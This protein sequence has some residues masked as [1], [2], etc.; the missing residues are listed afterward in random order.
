MAA[1]TESGAEPSA[2]D[3]PAAA[4]ERVYT[5][6]RPASV[7]ETSKAKRMSLFARVSQISMNGTARPN[8]A[9]LE[10]SANSTANCEL[11]APLAWLAGPTVVSGKG[12]S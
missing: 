1:S 7:A 6:S 11:R 5:T 4:E 2:A 9:S 12:R 3:C 8:Y 10:E